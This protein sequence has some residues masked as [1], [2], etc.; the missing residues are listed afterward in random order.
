MRL[1][2]ATLLVIPRAAMIVWWVVDPSGFSAAF[3]QSQ[4]WPL[5]FFVCLP[6]AGLLLLITAPGGMDTVDWIMVGFASVSDVLTYSTWRYSLRSTSTAK[7][8][9]GV[10]EPGET[11][12]AKSS[13]QI[14]SMN[15]RGRL[16]RY[17]PWP[18]MRLNSAKKYWRGYDDLPD[19]DQRLLE[20]TAYRSTK[21]SI[22]A[23]S[24]LW[25]AFLILLAYANN[26]G[27]S[28]EGMV[29]IAFLG[30]VVTVGVILLSAI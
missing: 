19:E 23:S 14:R 3:W 26:S 15:M 20:A 22:A 28:R 6:Y 10:E 25:I 27:I 24:H 5:A 1:L 9:A 17:L 11:A 21:S 12:A 18:G 16:A 2:V 8:V 29:L 13:R 7:A 4:I 30:P